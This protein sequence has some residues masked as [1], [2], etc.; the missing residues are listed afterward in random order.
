MTMRVL[1]IMGDVDIQ[2]NLPEDAEVTTVRLEDFINTD[3]GD[4]KFDIIA[5][6]HVLQTLW[7]HEVF[8]AIQKLVD[9]LANK[10]ELYIHVPGIE[11]AVKPLIKNTLDPVAFYLIWG[12]EKT[13][14]HTGFTLMWLRQLVMKAGGIVRNANVGLFNLEYS[15]KKVKGIEHHLLATVVRD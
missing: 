5:C 7:S 11:Q 9:T 1:K 2:I 4:L 10:G 15:G 13:P 12:S 6:V 14:F 8:D 3:Y